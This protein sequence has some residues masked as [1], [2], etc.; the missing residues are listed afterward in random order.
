MGTP[1]YA[2]PEQAAGDRP[3]GAWSDVYS[4]GLVVYE[5]VVG[6]PPFRG[7]TDITLLRQHLDEPPPS[8]RKL[9]QGIEPDLDNK[10]GKKTVM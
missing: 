3:I 4:L 7:E 2:S 1:L 10:I 9:R 8:L 6:R 5:M